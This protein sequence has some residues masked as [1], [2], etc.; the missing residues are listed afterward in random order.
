M[1]GLAFHALD[2]L[3]GLPFNPSKYVIYKARLSISSLVLP[4]HS[5]LLGRDR[6]LRLVGVGIGLMAGL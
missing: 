2:F 5:I 1:T 4:A 3:V 6:L